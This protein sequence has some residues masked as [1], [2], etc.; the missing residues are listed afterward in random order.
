MTTTGPTL[1]DD[2]YADVQTLWNFHLVDEE[3]APTSVAI[4]LGSHDLGVATCTAELYHRGLFPLIVFT[5]ANSPTTID[6]FP[7]GEAVHYR[8]HAISLGVPEDAILIETQATDTATNITNTRTL[9]AEHGV[10]VESVTLTSRPY[11]LRRSWAMFRKLWPEVEI[12]CASQRM[13]LADYIAG[14]GDTRLVVDGIVG[15]TQR[16][17]ELPKFGLAIIQDV[18]TEVADAYQ[19]LRD[20]GFTSRLMY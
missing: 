14:I 16:L 1:T 5:G 19:R 8:E 20:A 12:R 2:L 15:D 17:V 13:P 11:Q 9:L 7:R 6:R 10:Q 4:G 18:P 3:L